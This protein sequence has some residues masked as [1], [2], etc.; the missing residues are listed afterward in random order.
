MRLSLIPLLI[1]LSG[2]ADIG[3][4][5]LCSMGNSAGYTYSGRVNDQ[6]V[7]G[8]VTTDVSQYRP[9]G[10]SGCMNTMSTNLKRAGEG[11][12]NCTTDH[13]CMGGKCT[14]DPQG[15]MVCSK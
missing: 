6:K 14:P 9:G 12:Q 13:D 2:C 15:G 3:A 1:L 8:Y 5:A 4:L 10:M 7:N 11:K